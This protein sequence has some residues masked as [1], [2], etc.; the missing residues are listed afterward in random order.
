MKGIAAAAL[1]V[2]LVG[3]SHAQPGDPTRGST[4]YHTTYKCTDC[5]GDPPNPNLPGDKFLHL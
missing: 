1:L 2:V 5:H 3:T 4:L